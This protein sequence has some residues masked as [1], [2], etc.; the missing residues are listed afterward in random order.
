MT[1]S[2]L[3]LARELHLPSGEVLERQVVAVSDGVVLEWYPFCAECESMLLVDELHVGKYVDG[4]FR[5][6]GYLL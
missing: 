3:Y 4:A 5:V 2:V 6:D 1:K